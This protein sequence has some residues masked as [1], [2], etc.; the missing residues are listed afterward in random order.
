MEPGH[1][2]RASGWLEQR[3]ARWE[4]TTGCEAFAS[5][6]AAF[7]DLPALKPGP[8]NLQPNLP[9]AVPIPPQRRYG[10]SWIIQT[11]AFA[12]DW[13]DTDIE[14][15]G[16]GGPYSYWVADTVAAVKTCGQPNR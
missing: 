16:P 7:R 12:P 13:S 1:P 9:D 8:I 14:L 2:V 15:R 10:E 5:A 3:G 4:F 11:S 6:L